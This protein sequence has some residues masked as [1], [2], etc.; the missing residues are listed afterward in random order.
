MATEI[1]QQVPIIV[2]TDVG[3]GLKDIPVIVLLEIAIQAGHSHNTTGVLVTAHAGVESA[4][5]LQTVE[6][7]V[8]EHSWIVTQTQHI[9]IP[10]FLYLLSAEV[11]VHLRLHAWQCQS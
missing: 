5:A 7:L 9:E 10:I 11:S 2:G 8:Q 4:V 6:L 1:S 3:V